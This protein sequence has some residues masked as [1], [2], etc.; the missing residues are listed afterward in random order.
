ML[1]HTSMLLDWRDAELARLRAELDQARVQLAGCLCASEG[2]GDADKVKQGDYAWTPALQ[3]IVEI[4]KD[5]DRLT[6]R[7]LAVV[8]LMTPEQI[9]RFLTEQR[10][11]ETEWRAVWQAIDP[12]E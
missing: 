4:R 12:E 1:R 11:P 10:I 5:R 8:Q 7:Y 9:D 2:T 6:D 3:C